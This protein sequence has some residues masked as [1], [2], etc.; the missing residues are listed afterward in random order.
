MKKL[1][2]EIKSRR[3]IIGYALGLLVVASLLIAYTVYHQA[4][5][6]EQ[7]QQK[8]IKQ[9]YL[10]N[11]ELELK[12]YITLARRSIAHLYDSGR[13]D[14]AAM[15][16][17]KAILTKLDYGDDGYFSF[18]TMKAIALSMRASG[19][20]LEPSNGKLRMLMAS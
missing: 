15:E 16:E 12:N 7:Q 14:A 10:D 19:I 5:V 4:I 18:M 6:L 3:K 8:V 20:W 1:W 13:T 11:K 2:P 17:A 9:T